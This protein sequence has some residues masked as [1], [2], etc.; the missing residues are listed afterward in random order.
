LATS[1]SF[2]IK[3]NAR[4]FETARA[5][6]GL[7]GNISTYNWPH[8]YVKQREQTVKNMTVRKVKMLASQYLNSDQMIWLFVGDA[9]TQ[10]PRMKTLGFGEPVLLNP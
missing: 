7:L 2:L 6:L 9:N 3:S 4:A 1:K 8:D 10:L 5:K